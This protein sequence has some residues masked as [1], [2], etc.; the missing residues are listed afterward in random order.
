[1]T[2]S[3]VALQ[4]ILGITPQ[5]TA[6]SVSI[7]TL[8]PAATAVIQFLITSSLQVQLRPLCRCHSYWHNCGSQ[9]TAD[10][11][12][13]PGIAAS[14]SSGSWVGVMLAEP[15]LHTPALHATRDLR[16]LPS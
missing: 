16:F 1:M 3:C 9:Q 11:L 4:V 2:L 12:I 6:L 15:H 7:G 13:C 5:P 10:V 8:D 14:S